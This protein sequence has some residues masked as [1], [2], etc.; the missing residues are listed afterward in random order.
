M[1]KI[2][3]PFCLFII[4]PLLFLSTPGNTQ[5]YDLLIRNG[6]VYDGSGAA[7]VE[8]DVAVKGEKIVKI[9][10]RIRK[11][12]AK[13]IDASGLCVSP[14]FIDVHAH[15][16][17]L[18]ILPEAESHVRQGVTTA[19][20]GPDGSCPLPLGKYLDE[21][22]HTGVGM[23]IAHLVG[24]NT[25]R[26]H[27]MGLV[28]RAPTSSELEEMKK[29]IA[30]S[31]EEGAFGIST[32]LKYLPG[33][34]AKL[35]EV[36]ELSKVAAGYGGIYT[37]HLREEGLGL[38]DGVGEAIQ[39]AEQANIPVVLTHHKVVGHPMWG[40]SVKTLGM[41]DEARSKGLDVMIDQYPYTASYTWL[42][43]L[44]PS[45]ALEGDP[46]KEFSKRCE[47]PVLR[48]SIKQA[49]IF[50]LTNDRGGNDL[51]RVQFSR[52]QW[53]PE[54]EGKTLYDWAVAEGL[55]PNIENGAELIIQAQLHLGASC[56]FHAMS[57]ED[58]IR[59]M[60]HPY[61][62]IA[63]DGRLNALDKGHPH[64]RAYSTFPRVLGHYSRE[65]GVLPL[66]TALYKMT[67]LPASRMGLSD[68]GQIKKEYFADITIFSADR[69]IDKA[70]FLEPHQYPEGIE[71]VIVNGKVVL[72]Q[73]K[74][75]DVRAG[76]VLRKAGM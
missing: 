75:N 40:S 68:R 52:F 55:E 76:R 23:N 41:V 15:L 74:Y 56:I 2:L 65:K 61:T 69:I 48:D 53:K 12:A 17:P 8:M 22:S 45:W 39:I 14:G 50:N 31:M 6:L 47:D 71:Y 34:Y 32:G 67:G 21:L 63:S 3:Q 30:K 62:M 57:E 58:V 66:E 19:L 59:I 20:G 38:L 16:E 9:A 72:E 4:V 49:I 33:T 5:K 18:T 29:L 44:I 28:D 11:S 42:A 35:D 13:E 46:Y 51:K 10:R 70:T 60:Q 64:P 73:G 25:V 37:S 27:V 7:P 1:A 54:F 43:I 24:H 26:N 36:V